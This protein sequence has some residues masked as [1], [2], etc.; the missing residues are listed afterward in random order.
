MHYLAKLEANTITD[1]GET[2]LMLAA[3]YGK[4][5]AMRYL[6][7]QGVN[8][9]TQ[10]RYGKNAYDYAVFFKQTAAVELLRPQ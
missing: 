3:Q 10:D 4:L 5:A 9:S 1:R 2:P 7:A 8:T 6:L